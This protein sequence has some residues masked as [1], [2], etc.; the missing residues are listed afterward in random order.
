M[1]HPP[2]RVV[3]LTTVH[4]RD[5]VRIFRKE[6]ISLSEAGFEVH[7]CVADGKG[8]ALVQGVHIHDIGKVHGRFKRMALQPWRMLR[9]ARSLG[10][11]VY[12]FHD[13]ELLPVG[14]T[15]RRHAA[16]VYDT[17]EDVPRAVLS[18]HWIRP[19]LRR[20]VASSFECFEDAVSRRLSA[21]VAATPH[22]AKRF[23]RLNPRS[24]DINNYPLASE[25]ETDAGSTPRDNRTVCYLGGI[26]PIRG[27]YEMVQALEHVNARLLLAGPF[28]KPSTEARCRA[29]PGW[30]K[31]DYLGVVNRT[32]VREVMARSHAGLL[33]FHPEPNHVDAQPNKMF[34][35]MSAGLPVIASHFPLW[36]RV[37]LDE[38]AGLC[39]NPLDPR[40][41][42]DAITQVLDHPEAA[43]PMG[44]RGRAAVLAK[45][46]WDA[47]ATKLVALYRS[48]LGP[49]ERAT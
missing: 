13:P 44:E 30:A 46:R 12:H 4:Q 39:V 1:N 10:G 6:C 35:Y 27:A 47:E 23:G 16:V 34:E 9:R 19:A 3:H 33:L 38:G 43:R 45:Y 5:D 2:P 22:I 37:L 8:D 42:A 40:A 14:F 26:G 18:K 20:L 28:D 11:A 48:L 7:L 41:I 36:R 49:E 17:H 25:L 21:V 29:L 31:V 15:L 32:K 24:L